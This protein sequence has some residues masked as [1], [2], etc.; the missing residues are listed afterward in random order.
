MAMRSITLCVALAA[1]AA[2]T[3]ARAD[4][5]YDDRIYV[6]P[7]LSYVIADDVR[8]AEDGLG[9][10]LAIGM[11]LTPWLE[12]ELRGQ[13]LDFKGEGQITNPICSLLGVCPDAPD[14]DYFAGGGGINLFPDPSGG[15]YIHGDV[16]GG[17]ATYY[18]AG[19]GYE[20]AGVG[21]T[22]RLEAL[23]HVDDDAD[24]EE[25]QFNIG[26]RI[27]LGA[28]APAPTP[29]PVRIVPVIPMPTPAPTPVPSCELP[30]TA[31]A[32]S[33]AGCGPGDQFVLRGV[34]FEFDQSRLT[35]NAKTILDPVAAELVARPAIDIEIQGHT[36]S[37]G[38]DAYNQKLSE[39][40]AASVVQY[41]EDKG[42]AGE[43][44]DSTGYGESMPI[45]DNA[46]D[47]GR[48]LNRRVELKVVND[49]SGAAIEPMTPIATPV[50][51]M[52]PAAAAPV[53]TPAPMASA[54][55]AATPAPAAASGANAVSIENMVFVPATLRVA[56][57]TSVTWTNNDGSNHNVMFSTSASGRMKHGAT[58]TRS[59]DTPGTYD[60]QCSIHG[61]MMSGTVI[62]E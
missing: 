45:A 4:E 42:V 5:T 58:Y 12:A 15:F 20:F 2:A 31:G 38:S 28:K 52:M 1:I 17:D 49:K 13:Y 25:P 8:H 18:N 26:W 51:T 6:M 14:K 61:A 7:M 21:S 46:T 9:G 39:K 48:E 27:P 23:Y 50:P 35:T 30:A 55:P 32:G 10:A 53:A 60:Y 41:L 57:G 59:F 62:V 40:R 3:S 54:M 11:R 56:K 43:R 34:N 33:M 16:M 22:L 24:V 36:D 19:I 47:E 44:M 29:E 37:K